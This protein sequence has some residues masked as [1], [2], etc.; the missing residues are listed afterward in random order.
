V[1]GVI[2]KVFVREGDSIEKGQVLAEM[3]AWQYR[4]SLAE[5]EAGYRTA[6]LQMNRALASNNGT[7]AG[8]QRVHADYW[9]S[10]VARAR[11]LLEKTQLRS[12]ITGTVATPHIENLVGRKL[13]LGDTFGEV[14]DVSQ[15]IVDV[16][17]DDADAGLI[18][19]GQ[20]AVFKMNSNALRTFDGSVSVVSPHAVTQGGS[21][22]FYARVAVRNDDQS[23][24]TGMEGR[25]KVSVGWYPSGYVLFRHP[26][27]WIYSQVWSWIGW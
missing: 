18:K 24:R 10:Q 23:L 6:E 16:A 27:I 7:E 13:E 20:S 21:S 15:V 3:N 11:E 22:V 1:E 5:A 19:Q 4:T 25:G 14:V 2:S 8:M 9:N 26:A 17:V 12:P